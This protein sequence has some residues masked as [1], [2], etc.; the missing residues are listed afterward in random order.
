M[1][2]RIY[3]EP[4]TVALCHTKMETL[5]SIKRKIQ[6]AKENQLTEI[7]IS[8]RGLEHFPPELL[9][10]THLTTLILSNNYLTS[11]PESIGQ[12]I[13]LSNLDLH[14]NQLTTLPKSFGQLTNLTTLNLYNNKLTTLPESFGNLTNLI[15]L[16]LR[17]NNLKMLPESFGQMTNLTTLNLTANQLTAL[18]ESLIRFMNVLPNFTTLN[19]TTNQLTA[20][21]ESF[22]RF[23]NALPN[24]TTLN[25]TS[26]QLL[27]LQESFGELHNLTTLDLSNSQLMTLP[28]SFGQLTNLTTLN[29]TYNQLTTLPESF[30]QLTNLTTLYLTY[31][32]LTTLPESFDQLT[33]LR[34]LRLYGNPITTPPPDIVTKGIDAIRS[35]FKQQ[36]EQGTIPLYSAKLLLVGEPGA[37]KTTLFQKLLDPAYPVPND[38]EESTLGVEV[39]SGWEFPLPNNPEITF[40]ANL[41]DF[42]GQQIQ[43]LIHHFFL[44][45]RSLYVLVADDREQRTDF[46]Y[47]FRIIEL[48]GGKSPLLVVLNEKN[49]K[50]ISNFDRQK[51]RERYG[52]FFLETRDVDFALE[53]GRIAAL[54]QKIQEMLAALPHVGTPLPKQWPLI[55]AAL[56]ARRDR[57]YISVSEYFAICRAHHITR[58]EDQLLLS[59]YLH[60]LGIILH[61]QRDPSLASTIIVNPVWATKGVYQLLSDTTVERNGGRFS[62]AWLDEHWAAQGY[63]FEERG[64]LLALMLKDNFELCY[65]LADAHGEA[66]LAPQLLPAIQPPFAWDE[67]DNLRFRF[68]YPFLPHGLLSRLIVRL[69]DFIYREDGR[70]LI[71]KKGAVFSRDG[72]RARVIEDVTRREGLKVIDMAVSGGTARQRKEFLTWLCGQLD[73]IHKRSFAS[74]ICDEMIPCNCADCRDSSEPTY[75]EHEELKQYEREGERFIKCRKNRLKNVN[76]RGLLDGVMLTRRES[77]GTLRQRITH[78]LKELPGLHNENGWRALLLDAGLEAIINQITFNVPA[79]QFASLVVNHL[80][81]HGTLPDG[82][83]ALAALLEKVSE[84]IGF[85]KQQEC[86]QLMDELI[87]S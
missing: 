61:F 63:D 6:T 23:M 74:M 49:H 57:N 78:F 20:L 84:R 4:L 38:C 52:D 7:N 59:G 68:Q 22:I 8:R 53:D 29:L 87:F 86:Q 39:H 50:S 72:A 17:E 37:G 34:E 80:D 71:W 62:R 44:S 14:N 64:K 28:E 82:R 15:E 70:D 83:P 79:G 45:T 9:E 56:E 31:N 12:M 16:D 55:K 3:A 60:D 51:Y 18:P 85:D 21:P 41:W 5:Q 11:L 40:S 66:Y 26:P 81:K 19:L 46:D 13:N 65:K 1:T 43:Y 42:G 48:L 35:Y 69:S 30:G 75:F 10:L 25:L 54:R 76:V 33:K 47:W 58:E 27:S 24:L 32:Q 73:I 67:R 2:G 36:Q 77:T